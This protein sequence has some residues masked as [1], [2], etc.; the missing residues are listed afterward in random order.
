MKLEKSLLV[1]IAAAIAVAAIPACTKDKKALAK[2]QEKEKAKTEYFNCPA[3][4]MG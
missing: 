1:V 3:C 4:G 2:K